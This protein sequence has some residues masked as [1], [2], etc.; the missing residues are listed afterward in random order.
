MIGRHITAPDRLPLPRAVVSQRRLHSLDGLRGIAS[1]VVVLHHCAL[2]YPAFS[3]AYTSSDVPP[4]GSLLWWLTA[5]P[6]RM[7]TFGAESVVVFFVLSGMVVSIPVLRKSD[8]DWR[9]YLIS[10]TL[11]LWVP[12]AASVLLATFWISLVPQTGGASVSK[13]VLYRSSPSLDWA[14]VLAS[15]DALRGPTRLNNPL[16]SIQWELIFSLLLP[17]LV[18]I[19]LL[20]KTRP[21]AVAVACSLAVWLGYAAG[22]PALMYLP[23]FLVGIALAVRWSSISS[24]MFKISD[25]RFGTV[26]WIGISL[27]AALLLSSHWIFWSLGVVDPVIMAGSQVLVLCGAA[28]LLLI[29]ALCPLVKS[30]LEFRFAQWLGRISFSLYLVHAP[31]LIWYVYLFG[32]NQWVKPVLL[33]V[34]TSIVV[35]QLFHW[36]VERPSHKLARK[37]GNHTHKT[38]NINSS[39]ASPTNAR[40]PRDSEEPS[41]SV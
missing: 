39:R 31:I 23:V 25:H 14:E 8:F 12:V 9:S 3:D 34:P 28:G 19:A 41:V 6:V 24:A 15:L 1:L 17:L 36:G 21:I 35:A 32:A 33:A 2:A 38:W 20:L 13:W 7:M 27:S 4:H 11:R 26:M 30:V 10:R 5:T 29:A 40:H 22:V 16:W 18:W 37:I